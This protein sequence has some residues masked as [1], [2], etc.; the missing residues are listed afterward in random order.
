LQSKTPFAP[1]SVGCRKVDAILGRLGIEEIKGI[2]CPQYMEK[3]RKKAVMNRLGQAFL[4][5]E[6][7]AV[8][9]GRLWEIC[10]NTLGGVKTL[11]DDMGTS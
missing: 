9:D 5:Q 6:L 4:H 3:E 10:S 7:T 11:I 8:I 1:F 2:K